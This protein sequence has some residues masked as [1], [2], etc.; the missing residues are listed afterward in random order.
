MSRILG[1]ET[2]CDETAA[3]VVEDGRVIL[4][5]IVA[6]QME[7][8]RQYGG[9]FPEMAS[10]QHIRSIV[11]VINQALATA[12]VDWSDL[13]AVAVTHGPGLAGALLVGVNAA[14]GL[15]LGRRLPLIGINHLEGHVYANWLIPTDGVAQ[16]IEFPLVCLI[17]SGGHSEIVLMSDHG[18]YRRLGG[19]IDD[20]AGEAF[21][22]V[23]RILGLGY[24][25]GPA[26]Q[27]AA[28]RGKATA[29]KF[30]RAWLGDS[31]DFS[32]SGLK[33]AVLRVVQKYE[34]KILPLPQR[35][36]RARRLT[37]QEP[38]PL[39]GSLSVPNLAA[40][41]QEAVVDVLAEK[42]VRAA[43]AYK[44]KQI[45]LSG[46]VAANSVLRETVTSRAGVPVLCPPPSLCSDNAAMI[47]AAA[48][49][50]WLRGETSGWDLD[51][52]PNLR[53][54]TAEPAVVV[55]AGEDPRAH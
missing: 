53:L 54:A 20:A 45:V 38:L 43:A 32:F 14:K 37:S 25:G 48:Y 35:D 9:V 23:A 29:F 6:S 30:P 44:A 17:V 15:A 12:S 19:T 28:S 7:L 24:P 27:E 22:K 4:S 50:H 3:A 36:K 11:P 1:I 49:W 2:S 42:T 33:T 10:R 47:A 34:D 13:S 41:F 52:V 16:E 55:E 5:N 51:V 21:D 31:Y 39:A 40:G 46:G 26:I 18:Q 8:H